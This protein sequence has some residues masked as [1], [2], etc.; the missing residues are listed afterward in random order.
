MLLEAPMLTSP[1]G[2][3]TQEPLAGRPKV[4]P[5][6]SFSSSRLSNPAV[7]QAHGVSKARAAGR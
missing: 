4:G 3:R 1:L 5:W 2:V 6:N 7:K